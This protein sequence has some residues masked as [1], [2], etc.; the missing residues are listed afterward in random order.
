MTLRLLP[1]VVL[2]A[3]VIATAMGAGAT[4]SKVVPYCKTGQKSTTAR[5]CKAVPKCKTGQK[6]T[7]A[8]PCT[9]PKT[10]GST[11]STGSTA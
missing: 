7:K 4:T 5:P 3:V 6:S 1:L 11:G 8:K 2:A 10:T 9:K